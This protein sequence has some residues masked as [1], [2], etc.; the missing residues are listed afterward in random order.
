M[1]QGLPVA[2]AD[3]TALP[4]VG[5]DAGWYFP[6]EDEGAMAEVF[7]EMLDR[8]DEREQRV[9]VGRGIASGYRWDAANE[10]LIAALR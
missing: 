1:A 2:L 4:E 10:R 8:G 6:P 9:K 7:R 3:S 5:G